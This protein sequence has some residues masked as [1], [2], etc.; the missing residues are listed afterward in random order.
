MLKAVPGSATEIRKSDDNWLVALSHR[1]APIGLDEVVDR[2]KRIAAQ[3]GG[4]YD[5]W[6]RD[7]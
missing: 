1:L 4:D 6:E 5:G 3:R 7:V 2:L